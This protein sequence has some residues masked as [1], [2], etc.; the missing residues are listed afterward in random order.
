MIDMV[1][2][3]DVFFSAAASD[4]FEGLQRTWL[5]RRHVLEREKARIDAL[6]EDAVLRSDALA[7]AGD[8][9][10]GLGKVRELIERVLG[11]LREEGIRWCD[12]APD[13]VKY[14]AFRMLQDRMYDALP[15]SDE[16]L[17]ASAETVVEL[18]I[19][20]RSRSGLWFVLCVQYGWDVPK[21]FAAVA[22]E[23]GFVHRP[24]GVL[25]RG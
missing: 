8:D 12:P 10:L 18:V 4:V 23:Y 17:A 5:A 20:G 3:E 9:S 15:V 6:L 24:A 13:R 11:E 1:K 7:L 25:G 22:P 2:T 14:D 16:I 19:A 21:F